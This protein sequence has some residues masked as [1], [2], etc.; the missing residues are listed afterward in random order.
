MTTGIRIA[1]LPD[2]G[3]VT[4]ICKFVGDHSGSGVFF[5]SAF[6]TFVG[7]SA[8]ALVATIAALRANTRTDM[9]TV[10]VQGYSVRDDGG[11][12]VFHYMPGDTTSADDGGT[13]FVDAAG[14]RWYREWADE[15]LDLLWFG[16]AS[17]TD[18][19]PLLNAA[20]AVAI[21]LSATQSGI[22]IQL[23][24]RAMTFASA[25]TW[26]FPAAARAVFALSIEG[27]GIDVSVMNWTTSNGLTFNL[28]SDGHSISLTDLTIACATTNTRVGLAINQSFSLGVI[29]ISAIERVAFRGTVPALN[30]WHDCAIITGLSDYNIVDCSC[31]G[32]VLTGTNTGNGII[33][34]G[35][36]TPLVISVI[37]NLRGCDFIFLNECVTYGDSIQ[38]MTLDQCNMT[39]CTA[40]VHQHAGSGVT[41]IGAQL[42]LIN[43]QIACNYGVQIEGLIGNVYVNGSL[44]YAAAA[45]AACVFLT[46][47][48][49]VTRMSL[50]GN[51][52]EGNN[53]AG[54]SGVVMNGT[55]SEMVISANTLFGFTSAITSTGTV[56]G[57]AIQGNSIRGIGT[58]G[59][60]GINLAGTQGYL[61]ITGNHLKSL[62]FSINLAAA[63]HHN[64]VQSNTY[65]GVTNAPVNTGTANVIGGGSP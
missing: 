34:Q 8:V 64:N 29:A 39:G 22:S 25:V 3:A 23:P 46:A 6:K 24:G 30:C 38:G 4:D 32:A 56:D 5:G 20:L 12:G 53:S 41:T 43:C 40:G 28:T 45:S 65:N 50:A 57:G 55:A 9:S 47:G 63:T 19:A 18:Y 36:N 21:T 62:Q 27:A 52:F 37:Q 59:N 14:H 7:T 26:N 13:K 42:N 10:Y 48:S 54:S 2:L 31:I 44:L 35:T 33:C 16:G 58:S 61:A 60:L 15:D 49:N 17:V 11:G 1:D 51:G